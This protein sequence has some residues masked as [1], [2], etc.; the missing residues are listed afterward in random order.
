MTA[1][2]PCSR[3]CT[4][5][6][7][8]NLLDIN[9]NYPEFE[10]PNGYSFSLPGGAMKGAHIGSVKVLIVY[11]DVCRYSALVWLYILLFYCCLFGVVLISFLIIIFRLIYGVFIEDF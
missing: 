8:V 10:K 11:V 5:T 4:A 1:V 3:S 7:T 9:D 2:P 6:V